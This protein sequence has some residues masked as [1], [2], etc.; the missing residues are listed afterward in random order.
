MT[1]YLYPTRSLKPRLTMHTHICKECGTPRES[2]VNPKR[3]TAPKTCRDCHNRYQSAVMS[4][5]MGREHFPR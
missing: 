4:K 5:L 1:K 2:P 3:L